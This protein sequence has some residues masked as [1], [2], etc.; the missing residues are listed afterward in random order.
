VPVSKQ[1]AEKLTRSG[2]PSSLYCSKSVGKYN[3]AVQEKYYRKMDIF[4]GDSTKKGCHF[5]NPRK[6]GRDY[7]EKNQLSAT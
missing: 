4:P 1:W 6:I 2:A 3:G 5:E 7:D